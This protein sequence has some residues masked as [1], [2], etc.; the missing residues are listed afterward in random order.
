MFSEKTKNV[1][2]VPIQPPLLLLKNQDSPVS[3]V[4][5]SVLRASYFALYKHGSQVAGLVDL[6]MYHVPAALACAVAALCVLNSCGSKSLTGVDGD[7]GR[8]KG[9][10]VGL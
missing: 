10:P 8:A 9:G 4:P 6:I 7:D 2:L 1:S 3:S 5:S